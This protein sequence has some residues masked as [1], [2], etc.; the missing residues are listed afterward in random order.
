M[1]LFFLFSQ[2]RLFREEFIITVIS[3]LSESICSPSGKPRSYSA[4]NIKSSLFSLFVP[5]CWW[6]IF[7]GVNNFAF[8]IVN[9]ESRSF[10]LNTELSHHCSGFCFVLISLN[11]SFKFIR[12]IV[13]S[14]VSLSKCM[15]E[16]YARS[17]V[18]ETT[19]IRFR[20]LLLFDSNCNNFY[21]KKVIDNRN[22]ELLLDCQLVW[23]QLQ[24]LLASQTHP[25]QLSRNSFVIIELLIGLHNLLGFDLATSCVVADR[26]AV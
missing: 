14:L 18:S 25:F 6:E 5:H 11:L 23:F 2:I 3:L 10:H 20:S 16:R 12:M 22:C 19:K 8:S 4:L 1:L 7:F 9:K 24:K 13:R 26:I 15:V 21:L 17:I